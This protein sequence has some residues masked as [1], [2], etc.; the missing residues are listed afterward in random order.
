VSPSAAGGNRPEFI[1]GSIFRASLDR[2]HWL[3][4]GYER[5][6]L[7]VF[8]ETSRLL[9]PSEKGANP[10]AFSGSDLLLSGWSWP[11]NTERH[12]QNSVW[13]AVESMGKGKVVVFA[14]NPVYRGF[15]R[16]PAK[17]LTN[18]VLFAPGR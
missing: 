1:P 15:W 12:L 4:F 6:Q 9:K 11:G 13:A 17:L 5:D 14:E 7:A 16:G 10:V 8:L 3:T 2:T 18:A